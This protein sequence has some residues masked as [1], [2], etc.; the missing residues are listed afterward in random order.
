VLRIESALVVLPVSVKD[1]NYRAVS[2]LKKEDFRI[3]E[4]GVEQEVA[5]FVRVD[6]AFTVVLMLVRRSVQTVCA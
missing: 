3:Y 5:Y 4:A 2:D 6:D 1:R